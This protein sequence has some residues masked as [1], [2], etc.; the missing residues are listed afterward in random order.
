MI[1]SVCLKPQSSVNS[2]FEVIG[3]PFGTVLGI[4]CQRV[5]DCLGVVIV[6][7]Q[8]MMLHSSGHKDTRR[9][10]WND[11]G[12]TT[13]GTEAYDDHPLES[14]NIHQTSVETTAPNLY[15][16]EY[17]TEKAGAEVRLRSPELK[18]PEASKVG[19]GS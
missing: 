14:Q 2:I 10:G 12:R 8:K 19:I 1:S 6:D 17:I 13:A 7:I 5:E 18:G 3:S 11:R 15:W 4:R 16:W 9:P